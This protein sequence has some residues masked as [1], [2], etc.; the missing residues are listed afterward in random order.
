MAEE[1]PGIPPPAEDAPARVDE[2]GVELKRGMFF[3]TIAMLASI[4]RGVFILLVA[5]LLGPASLGTFSIAWAATDVVSKIGIFGLDGAITTFIARA[6]AVG[7]HTRSRALFRLA[8]ALAMAQSIVLAIVVVGALEIRQA[9]RKLVVRIA[10]RRPFGWRL[11]EDSD[12]A[13]ESPGRVG[14]IA[15]PALGAGAEDADGGRIG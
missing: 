6:E 14:G 10:R 1:A 13:A 12:D 4:L 8:V 2:T 7:D 3:N 15:R 11:V 9:L 5:R